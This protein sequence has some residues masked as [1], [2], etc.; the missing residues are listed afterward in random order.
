MFLAAR[1]APERPGNSPYRT[2]CAS[3]KLNS[4]TKIVSR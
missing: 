3:P 4:D 2:L 1:A